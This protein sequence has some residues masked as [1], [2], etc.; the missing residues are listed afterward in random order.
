MTGFPVEWL[1]VT[2]TEKDALT[3]ASAEDGISSQD[4]YLSQP[5]GHGE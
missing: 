4:P 2:P 5:R 3:R 1:V